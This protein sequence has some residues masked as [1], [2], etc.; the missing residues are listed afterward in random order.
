[1]SFQGF[2]FGVNCISPKTLSVMSWISQAVKIKPITESFWVRRIF[3]IDLSRSTFNYSYSFRKQPAASVFK[4]TW[5]IIPTNLLIKNLIYSSYFKAYFMKIFSAAKASLVF[6]KNRCRSNCSKMFFKISILK[7]F[8]IFTGKYL[9]WSLF[10]IKLQAVKCFP[11]NIAKFLS[12][13]FL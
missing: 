12:A 2:S 7:I 8:A 10:L 6:N 3:E 5:A 9:C 4:E 1:M 13:E 11:V